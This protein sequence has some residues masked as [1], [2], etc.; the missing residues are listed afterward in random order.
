LSLT[1]T[2]AESILS[3]ISLEEHFVEAS[4]SKKDNAIFIEFGPKEALD[5]LLNLSENENY[6]ER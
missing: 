3:Q 6:T 5:K 4:Q 2:D 1:L